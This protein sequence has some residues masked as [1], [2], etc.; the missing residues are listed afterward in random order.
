LA[1]Y[2]PF[3]QEVWVA[4]LGYDAESYRRAVAETLAAAE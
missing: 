3:Y 2:P 4:R 1:L